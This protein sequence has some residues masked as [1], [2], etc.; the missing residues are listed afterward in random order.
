MTLL[1]TIGLI[2]VLVYFFEPRLE[3]TKDHT[4]LF[5]GEIP[6]RKFIKLW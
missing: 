3:I 5:Y 2:G 1:L 6:K 4:Y